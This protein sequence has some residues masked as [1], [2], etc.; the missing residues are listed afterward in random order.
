MSGTEARHAV[1]MG[2]G[3]G[4]G[5]AV[6]RRLAADGFSVT[7][8]D[9]LGAEA[10]TLAAALRQQGLDAHA[11]EADITSATQLQ[12]AMDSVRA[13]VGAAG[14][15]AAVNTV[16]IF[17]ERRSVLK[18]DAESYR[19]VMD[20]N[21]MGAFLFSQAVEP[22]LCAGAALV[23]IGSVNGA[24]PGAGLGVYK[25][26]KA[27]LHMLARCLAMELARDERRIRVNVVAPGWV[28]TP[29]ERLALKAEPGQAHPLDDPETAKWIPL[30][31]RTR[32][33]EV[34]AAVSFLCSPQASAI[35][36][37]TLY[38]DCGVV[39]RGGGGGG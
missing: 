37:Q 10:E 2:G 7:I 32:A 23:H 30:G 34:A 9:R 11:A 5:E 8:L 20:V 21:V 31:R 35:T 6:A 28:D 33:E 27:A 22:M 36:G 16:G 17:D 12:A 1:V 3:R 39:T 14:V 18:T 24:L 4:I 25:V 15:G 26:S 29:G 13:R 19:R 38:V